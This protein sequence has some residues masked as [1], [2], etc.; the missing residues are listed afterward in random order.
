MKI[1]YSSQAAVRDQR[2]RT[3]TDDDYRFQID[4]DTH[5]FHSKNISVIFH[6]MDGN[7][8]GGIKNISTKSSK[9]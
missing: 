8:C 4:T 2:C 3:A 6:T 9:F 5:Q 7:F 1:Y